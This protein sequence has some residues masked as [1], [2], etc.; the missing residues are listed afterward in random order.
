MQLSWLVDLGECAKLVWIGM[1]EDFKKKVNMS[2]ILSFFLLGIQIKYSKC[3]IIW[4]EHAKFT[5]KDT[6]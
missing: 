1:H 4:S 5:S 6:E 3:T 2:T